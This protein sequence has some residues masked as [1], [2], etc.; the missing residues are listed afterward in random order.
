MKSPDPKSSR[1]KKR[2]NRGFT[3]VE[4]S[5]RK[6]KRAARR[7]AIARTIN[8]TLHAPGSKVPNRAGQLEYT[9]GGSRKY[10]VA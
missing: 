4:S 9:A 7:S 5:T 8:G 6:G 2:A 3:S 10:H 1:S